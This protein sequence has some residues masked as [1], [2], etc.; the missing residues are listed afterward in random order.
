MLTVQ[1]IAACRLWGTQDDERRKDRS[2]GNEMV[3]TAKQRT[4]LHVAIAEYLCRNGFEV[5]GRTV[6]EQTGVQIGQD[7][8]ADLLEKKW[9]AVVRLQ[10]RTMELEA[11][12]KHLEA[13]LKKTGQARPMAQKAEG[14]QQ[15]P[16]G[17]HTRELTRHRSPVS[18]VIFHPTFSVLVTC[19]EDASIIAWESRGG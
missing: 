2:K 7:G 8:A 14:G 13:E 10:K 4:E 16:R 17:P 19:S 1:A 9:T 6:A 3:L 12:V 15:L 18:R 5:A 11:Q